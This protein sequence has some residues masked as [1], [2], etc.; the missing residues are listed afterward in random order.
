MIAVMFYN[1]AKYKGSALNADGDLRVFTDSGET[2]S[3]A[4]TGLSWAV[5]QKIFS[6]NGNGTITPKATS[7]RAMVAQIIYNYAK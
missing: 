4:K 2:A 6:G 3:W 5:A 7:T 1:F